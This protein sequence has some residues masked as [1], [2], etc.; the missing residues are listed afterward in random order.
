MRKYKMMEALLEAEGMKLEDVQQLLKSHQEFLE[1][2]GSGGRWEPMVTGG[3]EETGIVFGVYLGPKTDSG[4]QA[5]FAHKRLD[6]LPLQNNVNLSCAHL[7]GVSC[8]GVNFQC[9]NLSGSY[10]TD[11][12][13]EGVN[14]QSANLSGVDFSRCNLKSCNFQGADLTG[15]DFE[16]ADLTNSD[17]RGAKLDGTKFPGALMDNV[18]R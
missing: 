7:C 13:F 10:A 12:D 2:G 5:N 6:G 9:A 1:N 8:R 15:T 3:D 18:Q 16:N 11:S 14:F 4:N 17:L